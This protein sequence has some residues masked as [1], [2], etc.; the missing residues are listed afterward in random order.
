[1]VVGLGVHGFRPLGG[2]GW[3]FGVFRATEMAALGFAVTRWRSVEIEVRLPGMPS[4]PSPEDGS[5]VQPKPS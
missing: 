5:I 3:G 2:G 1:M 4:L